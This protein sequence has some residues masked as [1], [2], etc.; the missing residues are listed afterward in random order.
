[1]TFMWIPKR[2]RR[3]LEGK[4][5]EFLDRLASSDVQFHAAV[6]G[7]L[8]GLLT[9][10]LMVSFRLLVEYTQIAMLPGSDPE[11]YEALGWE[12]RLL[13][14]V[15]SGLAIGLFFQRLWPGDAVVGIVH[16]I[17]RLSYHQGYLPFKKFFLQFVGAA[18][19]IVGGHSIGREG[20]SVHMGAAAGSL[21]GRYIGV[22]NNTERILVA[23][24]T[25][26]AIA[27]S[28]NTPLAG[29]IF[30]MEV[31]MF[32][33]TIASFIPVILAAV[34]ATVVNIA[35][36]GNAPV[37]FIPNFSFHS[38]LEMP[39]VV[40][41]GLLAGIVATIFIRFVT[42]V[43]GYTREWPFTVK[44]TLAGLITGLIA[45]AYPEVMSIGYD[46]VSLALEGQIGLVFLLGI[47]VAK[48]LATGTAISL[49]VPGGVVGPALFLG[50]ITGSIVGHAAALMSPDYASEIGF[51]AL[52]GMAAMM[53]ALLQAPLAALTAI[54]ELTYSPTVI[55]PGMLAIVIAELLR[56]EAFHQPS[57]FM[58]L[59]KARG[60]VVDMNPLVQAL[61]RIGVSNQMSERFVVL[62]E[63]VQRD[64][65]RQIL[66]SELEPHWILVQ[67]EDVPEFAVRTIDVLR[68][69]EQF[70]DINQ[71][72]L[73]SI[74]VKRLA[75][76]G[77]HR[78]AT[79]Y[80]AEKLM[81]EKGVE[82]LYVYD[83][84]APAM[85]RV[86]GVIERETIELSYRL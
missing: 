79:L 24:G 73:S 80:E 1:M 23:C 48:M 57:I 34:S 17:E 28:F 77:I 83:M 62:P 32:E 25:A 49:G 8:V 30:A 39:Y 74:P 10:A 75:I 22:P 20:P 54:L 40:A 31:V 18:L 76:E 37:F 59:L 4:H 82:L 41:L 50:A 52:L 33:Y 70:P 53:S 58:S 35:V 66:E 12:W 71:I 29:V 55:F 84:P 67:K 27:A 65:V 15:I 36:F 9:G 69:L 78:R 5:D 16:V 7:L 6:L 60:L 26:A 44:T 38:L 47:L 81:Q 19:A 85:Y 45:L 11:A 51:Y 13:I 63:K 46:T 56:S 86:R 14:P 21:M 61:Q 43:G 2:T 42:Q 64:E 68:Y 72:D 3:W